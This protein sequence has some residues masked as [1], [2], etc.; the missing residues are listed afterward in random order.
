MV[1]AQVFG[2]HVTITFA[3]ASGH[4]ELN[5]F[6]PV[7]IFNLLQSTRLLTDA[8]ASFT[9]HCVVGIEANRPR[10]AELMGRSLMLVTALNPHIGYDNAARIAK[11]AH[12]EG[13]TLKEAAANSGWSSPSSSIDWCRRKRWSARAP[14]DRR[15]REKARRVRQ[16]I[17]PSASISSANGSSSRSGRNPSPSARERSGPPCQSTWPR[18]APSPSRPERSPCRPARIRCSSCVTGS[19]PGRRPASRR[20]PGCRSGWSSIRRSRP[21]AYRR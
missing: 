5:V 10:I 12:A 2:N 8:A 3:G 13:S 14:T 7:L 17:A 9:E 11:K 15:R 16:G 6:K 19:P 20:W 4:F 21:P 18:S 1:C